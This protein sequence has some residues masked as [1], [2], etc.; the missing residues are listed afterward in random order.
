M[1]AWVLSSTTLS[2]SGSEL[3]SSADKEVLDESLAPKTVYGIFARAHVIF[4]QMFRRERKF[5]ERRVTYG[6]AATVHGES[7]GVPRRALIGS[8]KM[9]EAK[10]QALWTLLNWKELKLRKSCEKTK[11]RTSLIDPKSLFK[12]F[13]FLLI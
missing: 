8:L 1:L 13:W 3:D 9:V 7:H 10:L 4:Q 12:T 5:G 2:T 11:R 6:G